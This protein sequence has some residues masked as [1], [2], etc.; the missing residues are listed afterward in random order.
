[1]AQA[2][3]GRAGKVSAGILPFRLRGPA[4]EVL[5]VHPG[6]PLWAN[7]DAGAWS[8]AKG[9]L[10]PG[11]Q[12]IVA[13][14]REL[15]EETGWTVAPPLA[16]LGTTTL[17]SGK[18]VH[19]FAGVLDVDPATLRSGTFPME[20]PRG[21]GMIRRFPEVDRAAWCAPAE[22]VRLLNPAQAVFVERLAAWVAAARAG[23]VP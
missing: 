14:V 2:V 10:E 13:A 9:E 6:G 21:S 4:L 15:R 1:M 20:W 16:P 7:K 23:G 12:P 17:K 19:A 11:E 18:V 3:S 5:I 8:I 22:A